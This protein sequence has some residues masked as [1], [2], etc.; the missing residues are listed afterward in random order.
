MFPIRLLSNSLIL[1]RA[2]NAFRHVKM[3]QKYI[4]EINGLGETSRGSK[5]NQET[6]EVNTSMNKINKEIDKKFMRKSKL[7]KE[8]YQSKGINRCKGK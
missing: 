7:N 2:L 1:W 6:T 4:R 8:I 3:R 5:S